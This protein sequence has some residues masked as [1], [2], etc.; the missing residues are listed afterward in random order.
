MNPILP[1]QSG[2][3][4]TQAGQLKTTRLNALDVSLTVPP[5]APDKADSV[6]VLECTGEIVPVEVKGGELMRL[7]TLELR[8][9]V[10]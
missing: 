6:I 1:V 4:A 8:S 5:D 2:T 9:I 3:V 7:R 10:E